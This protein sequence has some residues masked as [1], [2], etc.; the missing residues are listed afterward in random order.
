M[1]GGARVER[2]RKDRRHVAG[3]RGLADERETG[4]GDDGNHCGGEG[5]QLQGDGREEREQRAIED[6]EAGGA[7]GRRPYP[8]CQRDGA[9]GQD[10]GGPVVDAAEQ[11]G[12]RGQQHHQRVRRASDQAA[13]S[14]AGVSLP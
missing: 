13:A 8:D 12:R 3:H 2:E 11:R 4:R 9:G 7:C 14:V 1:N 10:D 6:A 5:N